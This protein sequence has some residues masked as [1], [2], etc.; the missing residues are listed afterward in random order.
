[1]PNRY[2]R[3]GRTHGNCGSAVVNYRENPADEGNQY[4][5]VVCAEIPED[6]RILLTYDELSSRSWQFDVVFDMYETI[7][8][9]PDRVNLS[10]VGEIT[11]EGQ[12][13]KAFNIPLWN[14]EGEGITAW[15]DAV[16]QD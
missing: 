8:F 12:L 11:T 9:Y 16:P 10:S 6:D 14:R 5:E 15:V 4:I 1:M 3:L 7:V 2:S 13:V